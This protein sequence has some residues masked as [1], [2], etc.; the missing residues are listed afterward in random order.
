MFSK[1]RQAFTLVELL[2]VIAIIGIL[3]GMLLPAV[4]QVRSAAR[5]TCCANKVRQ[6]ALGLHNFESANQRFPTGQAHVT[7]PIGFGWGWS[8]FLLPFIEQNNTFQ[9]FDLEVRLGLPPNNAV[10]AQV[11]EGALCPED[12]STVLIYE[13]GGTLSD[14]GIA[15]SNYVGC[16]G[17]FEES[18]FESPAVP[19]ESR[20]GMFARNS[21]VAFSA[22]S[23]GTSNSILLGEAVWFGDGTRA[24]SANSFAWDTVWY[25]RANQATN[26]GNSGSTTAMVRSGLSRIN[27]PSF[28]SDLEKRS[29]FGS[30]HSGGLN[31]ALVDGSVQFV[32]TEINQ[33]ETTFT[34]FQSGDVLGVFQALTSI[35]DGQTNAEF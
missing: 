28:A 31:F 11:Y 23:D 12:N 22:V 15:K 32:S 10:L 3:I 14:P 27:T 24:G 1:R 21:A 35:N 33:T 20:N 2:V 4:Q 7:G 6:L 34:E 9:L 18:I 19:A 16:S 30:F 29:A 5:R 13:V 17:A 25:G 26:G 8:T